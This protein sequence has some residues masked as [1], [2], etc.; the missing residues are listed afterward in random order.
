VIVVTAHVGAF[1]LI[2]SYLGLKGYRPHGVGTALKDD[3]LNQ[4]LIENRTSR[5]VVAIERGRETFKMLKTLKT[6]GMVV[7]LIDQDTRVKSR[8]VNFLDKPAAT[9]IGGTIM[10]QKTGASVIPIYITLQ[11]DNTQLIQIFPEVP[12]QSSDDPENDL[13]VNTQRLSNPTEKVIQSYPAQ[14]VW[15]HERWKTRPGEEI[16]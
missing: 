15:M 13:V 9:P 12:L 14:W 1:E 10:A 2:G 4:L 8:F 5:G 6:G 7:I 11:P 3:R 16:K